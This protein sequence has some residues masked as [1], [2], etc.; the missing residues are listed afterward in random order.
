MVEIFTQIWSS[1]K[2]SQFQPNK[3]HPNPK[4]FVPRA[5]LGAPKYL[6]EHAGEVPRPPIPRG[7][8][9]GQLRRRPAQGLCR[10]GLCNTG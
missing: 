3:L 10:A 4:V 7:R 9:L 8:Q 1:N 2:P 5:S 6:A